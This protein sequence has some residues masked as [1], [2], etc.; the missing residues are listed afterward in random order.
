MQ[1]GRHSS[2]NWEGTQ[3]AIREALS[4]QLGRHS[5]CLSMPLGRH[6]ACL[7]MQLGRHSSDNERDCHLSPDSL[8][9]RRPS[10]ASE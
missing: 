9:R 4:M 1:L 5:T 10:L 3:H 2:C 7:S 6:S 8:S